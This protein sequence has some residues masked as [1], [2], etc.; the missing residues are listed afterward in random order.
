MAIF[1]PGGTT[2]TTELGY[3]CSQLMGRLGERASLALIAAAYDSGI[4][5]FDVAPSYGFGAAERVLGEALRGKRD[6]VTLAT[7]FGLSPPRHQGL[8]AAARSVARPLVKLVPAVRRRLAHAAGALVSRARF[9]PEE[10]VRSLETSLVALRTDH[11]DILLLHEATADDL[12]D[13]LLGAL[14]RCVHAGKIASFGIGSAAGSA[15]AIWHADRRFCPVLQLEWSVLSGIAPDHPGSF[16]ITH[17]ALGA[18]FERLNAWL[19]D[20]PA[21]ARTWS[22]ELGVDV[23]VPAALSQLMLA[24]A[25]V[26]NRAGITLFSSTSA[27]HIRRNV[28]LLA[29]G[30]PHGLGA[31]FARL[32]AR[33]AGHLMP[34]GRHPELTDADRP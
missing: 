27:E 18:S 7:K 32:A 14:E 22:N 17:R 24:A 33:D 23:A 11:V 12:D 13:A 6:R 4:R 28:A 29:D 15:A 19:L 25:R 26:A 21:V 20:N 34:P 10:L 8:V 9:A 16:V 2:P 3:G 1:L 5:H 30:A 31:A